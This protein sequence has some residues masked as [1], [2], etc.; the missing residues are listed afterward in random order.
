VFGRK[1]G[2][3]LKGHNA[4]HR[5]VRRIEAPFLFR[6]EQLLE[7]PHGLVVYFMPEGRLFLLAV[8]GL[9]RRRFLCRGRYT[10]LAPDGALAVAPS[11]D[12]VTKEFA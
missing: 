7:L 8:M 5:T 3:G 10:R 1:E 6:A 9:V 2:G 11:T 4:I 12:G